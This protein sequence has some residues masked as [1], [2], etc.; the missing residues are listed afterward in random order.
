MTDEEKFDAI[1]VGAGPAGIAAA[2]TMAKANLSVVVLEKGA[3]PGSKNLFGGILFGTFLNQMIPNFWEQAP[4]ERH[5]V[6]RRFS[7]LSKDGEAA[8][9]YRSERYNQPPYN[10]CFTV[11]RPK[12]DRWF[13][14]QAEAA[15]AEIYPEVVVDDFVW[16][17]GKVV[18]IKA[19]GEREGEYDELYSHA[20]VC[21]E[22]AN[23]MLAEK[24]GLRKDKSAMNPGNRTVAVK[25]VI[26][27][28]RQVIEDRFH[29]RDDEGIAIEYFG[30]AV[31][32]MVGS[33]FIYTNK[34]SISVG[35]GVS[36]EDI[37]EA[38]VAPYDLLDHFKAHPAVRNLVRGGEVVEYSSHMIGEDNYTRLPQ[39]FTHGLILVGDSAGFVNTSIYHEVTN[40]AMA[41]GM[42][43]GQ[44][45]IEA[46]E[47]ND[48]SA[49]SLSTY[50]TKLENSFIFKDMQRYKGTVD[51]LSSNQYILNE[52]PEIMLELLVDLFTVDETPKKE[53]QKKVFKKFRQK[54]GYISFL[55]TLWKAKGKLL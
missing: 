19:R 40:M 47:K 6:S 31:Q 41:S 27:L 11:I 20:V 24:A 8:F 29:L 26:K 2:Y 50:K 38:E 22:G 17:D 21:A 37:I 18:G 46:K 36:I 4:L 7:L 51:F 30:E 35:V 39:L 23:S 48:F 15:G 14:E 28:P 49:D 45:V 1:V 32:G 9:D 42:L 43:A 10:N 16:K 34:E 33:G 52:Y 13:A 5:V 3:Y 12:F 44:S 25:E 54:I 53:V 55:K